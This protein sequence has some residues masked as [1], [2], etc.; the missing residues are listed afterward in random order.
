MAE[1]KHWAAEQLK[2]KRVKTPI[3]I[4][5][6][7]FIAFCLFLFTKAFLGYPVKFLGFEVNQREPETVYKEK[8]KTDTVFV[9]V[10]KEPKPKNEPA[11][12]IVPKI[13]PKKENGTSVRDIKAKNVAVGDNN[14]VGDTYFEKDI[15]DDNMAAIV[16]FMESEKKKYGL[17]SKCFRIDILAGV[18]NNNASFKL[19][20]YLIKRGYE[21][22]E[23]VNIVSR[24]V[25]QSGAMVIVKEDCVS[26]R[27]GTL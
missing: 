23:F 8:V 18:N 16:E 5:L 11:N 26:I 25:P 1:R 21:F 9:S 24:D 14:K 15:T 2:D 13:I 3:L 27:L 12:K 22:K 20:D 6:Y 19:K 17:T 4:L 7:C 10:E